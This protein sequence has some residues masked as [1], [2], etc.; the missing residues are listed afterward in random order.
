MGLILLTLLAFSC[1]LAHKG[2]PV[3]L[4]PKPTPLKRTPKFL[5]QPETPAVSK[6]N[7]YY[8]Y[9]EAQLAQSRGDNETAG[10]YQIKAAA[11]DPSSLLLKEELVQFLTRQKKYDAALEAVEEALVLKPDTVSLL[12]LKGKLTREIGK[13]EAAIPIFEQ[14][15]RLDPNQEEAYLLLGNTYR[16]LGRT[17]EALQTYQQMTQVFPE[18]ISGYF[19]QGH[20]YAAQKE[21][22][23]AEKTF[24]KVLEL[25]PN[26]DA[27]A[28]DL[29]KLYQAQKKMRKAE[30]QYL[31]VIEKNPRQVVAHLQLA[32]FYHQTDQPEKAQM[33]FEK[34]DEV[35]GGELRLI[36]AISK[37][38]LEH[39]HVDETLTLVNKLLEKRANGG[40]L[41]YLAGLAYV[42]KKEHEQAIFHFKKV[43]AKHLFF[44][45]ATSQVAGLLYKKGQTTSAIS[46]L[47]KAVT[48][49]SDSPQL[50]RY[51][52]YYHEQ[53]KE[54]DHAVEV[55]NRGLRADPKNTETLY[56]LGIVQDKMGQWEAAVATMQKIL[57]FEPNN[58]SALNFIG[59]SYADRG[60]RL[61]EAEVLIKRALA[62][63]PDDGYILDS[64]GWVY[65]KKQDYTNALETLLLAIEQIPDDPTILEHLGDV[66]RQIDKPQ[67]ALDYYRKAMQHKPLDPAMVQQK[68]DALQ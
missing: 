45:D 61:D 32:L 27:V 59:Y 6:E 67:Q 17:E 16:E 21:Y 46:Y 20:L 22:R 41:H 8:Y 47:K 5:P 58:S 39:G 15:L 37:E 24:L 68:I 14:I 49:K 42:E 60:V 66:Y 11:L 4:K 34:L 56:R 55:L 63:K 30:K 28:V 64:L 38:Y 3:L 12:L 19:Y 51:L 57:V 26:L 7:P 25:N 65:Y 2:P 9:L 62:Q 44:V 50:Y 33:L 35:A 23:Q 1:Q 10:E 36:S 13:P 54:Y 43:T 31:A 52:G 40:G 53:Q 18:S 29:A 48:Q